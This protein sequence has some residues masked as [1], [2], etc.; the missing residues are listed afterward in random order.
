MA[1]TLDQL[2]LLS[3]RLDETLG[4]DAPRERFRRF[5]IEQAKDV[6]LLQSFLD[7]A[8]PVPDD[9]HRGAL[10]DLIVA[11][12]RTMG[13]DVTFGNY[14]ASHATPDP[15]GIWRSALSQLVIE[16]RRDQ[17]EGIDLS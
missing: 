2:L 10:Q 15:H 3:G 12:G 16:V 5:L 13:C 7:A 8:I 6:D 14:L 11:L 4:F 9:Q 1:I 17:S